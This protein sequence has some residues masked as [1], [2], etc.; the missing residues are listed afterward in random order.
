M[1]K[2]KKCFI[3]FHLLGNQS[4]ENWKRYEAVLI[5]FGNYLFQN[6]IGTWSGRETSL[7]KKNTKKDTL[8]R[9]NFWIIL[10]SGK[11]KAEEEL[12][13]LVKNFRVSSFTK[14]KI[15][16]T[17]EQ[18]KNEDFSKFLKKQKNFTWIYYRGD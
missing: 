18:Q 6:N 5:A 4:T 16:N 7:S 11:E 14:I 3:D 10:E 9:T 1:K 12:K 13:R 8:T 2:E 17:F 15:G